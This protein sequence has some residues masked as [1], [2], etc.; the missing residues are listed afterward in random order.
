MDA[1]P[2]DLILESF[3]QIILEPFVLLL[4]NS[5]PA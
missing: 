5:F 4:L 3:Q 1:K 2:N